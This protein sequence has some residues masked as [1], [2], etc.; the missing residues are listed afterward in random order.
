LLVGRTTLRR[1]APGESDDAVIVLN[2]VPAQDGARLAR[3]G[4]WRG[5]IASEDESP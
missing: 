5:L 2:V 1:P 4:V 3:V